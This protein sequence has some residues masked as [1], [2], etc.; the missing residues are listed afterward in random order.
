MFDIENQSRSI[1]LGHVEKFDVIEYGNESLEESIFV[2]FNINKDES[3]PAVLLGLWKFKGGFDHAFSNVM[4]VDFNVNKRVKYL[5]PKI[6][7]V[8]I[9]KIT[10]YRTINTNLTDKEM[11]FFDVM[12]DETSKTKS[13]EFSIPFQCSILID[14]REHEVLL[15]SWTP[16]QKLP[17]E[18]IEL[19]SK[20]EIWNVENEL[21]VMRVIKL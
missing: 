15:P 10:S 16:I 11:F 9:L 2:V 4:E 5:V 13:N 19:R 3:I 7:V 20:I 14:D 21:T 17:L 18:K 12:P 8:E 1:T 6:N